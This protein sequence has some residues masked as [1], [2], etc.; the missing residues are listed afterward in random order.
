MRGPVCFF[1]FLLLSFCAADSYS[2][3]V[4]NPVGF[5]GK[6]RFAVGFDYCSIDTKDV[7]EYDDMVDHE[8]V[9]EGYGL[10]V[11]YGLTDVLAVD[12]RFGQADFA[13][14]SHSTYDSGSAWGLGV[15]AN[16]YES[17]NGVRVMAGVQYNDYSPDEGFSEHLLPFEAEATDLSVGIDVSK[18]FAD[19]I[20]LYGGVQ[21]SD[22]TL[23][24]F[25]DGRYGQREGGFEQ[26]QE[27]GL[28][29]GVDIEIYKGFGAFAEAHFMNEEAY[30]A[31]LTYRMV[32]DDLPVNE[33]A[34]RP[35]VGDTLLKKL[36]IGAEISRETDRRMTETGGFVPEYPEYRMASDR[37]F[38]CGWYDVIDRVSVFGKIGRADLETHSSEGETTEFDAEL[39]WGVGVRGRVLEL[40]NGIA[41]SGELSY[42]QFDPDSEATVSTAKNALNTPGDLSIEWS[43]WSIAFDI[44][45]EIGNTDLFAG[46]KYTGIT[47]DQDREFADGSVVS[48]EFEA[49]DDLGLFVGT[50]CWLT[51]SFAL[52]FVADFVNVR[53]YTFG[54][55]MSF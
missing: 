5:P 39:A 16:V 7:F 17:A 49:E 52:T 19:R 47:A 10:R 34:A 27:F 48:S 23:K 41:I 24:Y 22:L 2:T 46:F 45:K 54:G 35:T 4:G 26:D 43:E 6:G 44:S 30:V 25:H 21:H 38:L 11:S 51:D 53:G 32:R 3:L 50:E 9:S 15:R 18:Q 55:K 8:L 1:P 31:G 14:D 42:L 40:D 29:G 28:Y 37:L 20:T 13:L 12:A 36:H 33:P